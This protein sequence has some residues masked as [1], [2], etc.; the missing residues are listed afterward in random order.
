MTSSTEE[1]EGLQRTRQE[2]LDASDG[3]HKPLPVPRSM[4]RSNGLWLGWPLGCSHRQL[5]KRSAKT[6][7]DQGVRVGGGG[8][9]G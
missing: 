9:V 8:S 2:P 6:G 7:L 4:T 5:S 1:S 3:A